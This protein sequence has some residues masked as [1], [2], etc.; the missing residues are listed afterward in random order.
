MSKGTGKQSLALE[1]ELA[2]P[3]SPQL[4]AS[5]ADTGGERLTVPWGAGQ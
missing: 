3:L 2:L 5:G 4:T 1:G